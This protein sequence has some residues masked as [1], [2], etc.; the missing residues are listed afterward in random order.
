MYFGFSTTKEICRIFQLHSVIFKERN[1][2]NGKSRLSE[3][4]YLRGINAFGIC[5]LPKNEIET[6]RGQNR[7]NTTPKD[8][9]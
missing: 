6:F 4:C 5:K 8:W 1:N 7:V 9:E 3:G 2:F